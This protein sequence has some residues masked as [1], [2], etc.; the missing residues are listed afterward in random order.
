MD[1]TSFPTECPRSG[2]RAGE[3]SADSADVSAL[4]LAILCPMA[5]EHETAV[6]FV[7]EMLSATATFR[8]VVFL[9]ILDR[10]STDGTIDALRRLERREP[11]LRV[12]WAPEN[13]GTVDA[14]IRGYR[15][16]L[17]TGF[18]WIL[19]IDAG[20]SH[21][22]ADLERFLPHMTDDWDCIFGSRFCRGGR[23][24]GMSVSR[25]VISRGGTL[26]TNLLLGTRLSDMTSGY[27]MFRRN[28]LEAV[29]A[30]GIRSRGHFFQT[31]IKV[32]CRKLRVKEVPIHYSN[33][34]DSVT[35]A[36]L[37]DAFRC[38]FDLFRR[39]IGGTL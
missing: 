33:P 2:F 32:Y 28:V 6:A 19:E 9:A 37:R 11:R 17:A 7:E 10:A 3:A 20:F 14:Y 29:L 27:Q 8:E 26:L 25:Y 1:A 16:A 23:V 24:S 13:R 31:E 12:V 5:N 36:S 35:G 22:P 39:R 18:E 38:L 4:R 34:S 30:R 21:S 15:E